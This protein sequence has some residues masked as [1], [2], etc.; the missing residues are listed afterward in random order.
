MIAN[1]RKEKE[2]KEGEKKERKET[3]K[4]MMARARV[5]R[6]TKD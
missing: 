4:Q 6:E 2:Q 3:M 5:D 1:A